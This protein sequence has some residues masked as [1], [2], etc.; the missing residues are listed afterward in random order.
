MTS[1]FLTPLALKA[2]KT[3]NS[4]VNKIIEDLSEQTR[5]RL[6]IQVKEDKML[7]GTVS[8]TKLRRL[9]SE[10]SEEEIKDIEKEMR[11]FLF[12]DTKTGL[13]KRGSVLLRTNMEEFYVRHHDELTLDGM[14]EKEKGKIK[15]LQIKNESRYKKLF[16]VKERETIRF[17]NIKE[18][19]YLY[20]NP[21]SFRVTLCTKLFRQG[22]HLD[23][24]INHLSEDMTMY[25]NKSGE[26]ERN[27]EDTV[28]IFIENSTS[29]GLIETDESLTKDGLLKEELKSAEF[30]KKI[31]KINKFLENDK[32]NLNVDMK[33]I[34]KSMN[35]T[36]ST[37]SENEFGVCIISVVQ[38]I[39]ERRKY[40]SSIDDHYYIGIQLSTF[41]D[42]N[43][44]YKRFKEKLMVVEH[45]K[46]VSKENLQFKNEYE[47]EIKALKYFVKKSL[48]VELKYLEKDIEVK[49]KKTLSKEYPYLEEIIGKYSSIKKEIEPWV[50]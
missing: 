36:G 29:E 37:L 21:H 1:T 30:K 23:Y 22:V 15:I 28:N 25:Y 40:F 48:A 17:K 8:I 3:L 14:S 6:M 42:I 34:V 50:S 19:K 7:K 20:T 32:L 12:L 27:L 26:F 44:S 39:C 38:R 46:I 2:Y 41:E 9:I 13:Q 31:E 45:N 24:I 10:Y 33:K 4:F 35:K 43:Y 16:N 47:R 49:G 18:E 11:R 5:L